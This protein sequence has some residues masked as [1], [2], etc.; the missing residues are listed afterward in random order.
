[1]FFH[2]FP[3]QMLSTY[4]KHVVY[5]IIINCVNFQDFFFFISITY[6]F[7]IF[8]FA[9]SLYHLWLVGLH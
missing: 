5:L 4:D 6:V 9:W 3:F 2:Q 1:M 8:H 7:G